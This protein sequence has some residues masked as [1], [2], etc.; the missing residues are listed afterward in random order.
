MDRMTFVD[1]DGEVLFHPE[2]FPEDEG[3]TIEWLLSEGRYKSL[4]QIA[5]RFANLEQRLRLYEQM[6]RDGRIFE[7]PVS[8]G[9]TVYVLCECGMIPRRLDG[10]LYG[11]GGGPGTATGY[12]CP[13]EDMC[14]HYNEDVDD[15][16]CDNFRQKS[17]V[18]EDVVSAITIREDGIEISTENCTVSSSLRYF[19]FLTKEEADE[20][21]RKMEERR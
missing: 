16:D 3:A 5:Q 10:T 15:F 9:D 7:L 11:D 1:E 13:Y 14:P 17:A 20:E 21:L 2:D 8:I 18:F 19:V 6:K 4:D 12:Y